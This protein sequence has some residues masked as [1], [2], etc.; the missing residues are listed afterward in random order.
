MGLCVSSSWSPAGVCS[1]LDLPARGQVPLPSLLLT[2]SLPPQSH[3]KCCS[4]SSCNNFN[5]NSNPVCTDFQNV[6][7]YKSLSACSAT[8]M[9]Q[10]STLINFT[11]FTA[12][13]RITIKTRDGETCAQNGLSYAVLLQISCPMSPLCLG[14]NNIQRHPSGRVFYKSAPH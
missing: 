12:S 3:M 11:C 2:V 14:E 7:C 1:H 5:E 8:S 9:K 4:Y 6:K 10:S 13:L